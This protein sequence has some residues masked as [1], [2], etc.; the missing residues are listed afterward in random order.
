MKVRKH[1]IFH[2]RVQGV[3]FRFTV[4]QLASQLNLTGWV[5]NQYDGTVEACVQGENFLLTEFINT[6]YNQ[7]FIRITDYE[8]KTLDLINDESSFQIKY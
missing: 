8:E 5:R 3:G 2:G 1:F 7:R 6:L 4:R